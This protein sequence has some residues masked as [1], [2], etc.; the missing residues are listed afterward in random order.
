MECEKNQSLWWNL[1]L[2]QQKYNWVLHESLK[3]VGW[4]GGVEK[5][6]AVCIILCSLKR[7]EWDNDGS[8]VWWRTVGDGW[9]LAPACMWR[10]WRDGGGGGVFTCCSRSPAELLA[11]CILQVP[12]TRSRRLAE[13]PLGRWDL[14][15]A[16]AGVCLQHTHTLTYFHLA[17]KKNDLN[18]VLHSGFGCVVN[19]GFHFSLVGLKQQPL[20]FTAD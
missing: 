1:I 20:V 7:A 12:G 6:R 4:D 8:D 17:K 11:D 9:I 15:S 5:E 16:S 2:W 19:C 3:R 18:K 10:E 13:G 14:L